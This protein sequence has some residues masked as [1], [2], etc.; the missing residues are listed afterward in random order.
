MIYNDWHYTVDVYIYMYHKL[1]KQSIPTRCTN[2][3][4]FDLHTIGFIK[5]VP[6]CIPDFFSTYRASDERVKSL[7]IHKFHET[8]NTQIYSHEPIHNEILLRMYK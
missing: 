3:E 7:M 5:R 8:G 6:I 1:A 4:I 2:F